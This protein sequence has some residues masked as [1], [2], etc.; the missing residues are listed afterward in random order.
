MH[1]N[2]KVEEC[3]K[4][5]ERSLVYLKIL[6]IKDIVDFI[7]SVLFIITFIYAAAYLIGHLV[8]FNISNVYSYI[9]L[10]LVFCLSL[11]LAV[12]TYL[13]SS[14]INPNSIYRVNAI[15]K[16][17]KFTLKESGVNYNI[18]GKDIFYDVKLTPFSS[19]FLGLCCVLFDMPE[20]IED[21]KCYYT[22]RS[23][24]ISQRFHLYGYKLDLVIDDIDDEE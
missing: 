19:K 10:V 3:L 2:K 21:V 12:S 20:N 1:C 9:F 11:M 16:N 4:N 14:Y 5:D 8:G 15:L 23:M 17:N 13:F 18:Q 22:F 24:L 6:S 7:L